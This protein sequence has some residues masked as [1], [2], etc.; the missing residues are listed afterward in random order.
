[1]TAVES[2]HNSK[3]VSLFSFTDSENCPVQ[4]FEF[5]LSKLNKKRDDLW[6]RPRKRLTGQEEEWFENAVIGRDPLE[7]TMKTLSI[8]AQLSK[9]YTNHSIRATVIGILD[10]HEFASRHIMAASGH[11]SESSIKSYAKKCPPKVHRDMSACLARELNQEA[12]PPK[13]SKPQASISK[14]TEDPS[15]LNVIQIPDNAQLI[16]A[17]QQEIS[18][19]QLVKVLEAIE[20]ENSSLALQQQP[21]EAE[22]QMQVVPTAQPEINAVNT[23]SNVQN[24]CNKNQVPMMYFHGSTVTINYNYNK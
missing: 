12:P 13:K 22:P 24:V 6:Q 15:V 16:E 10:E 20:K 11:K 21:Q 7:A 17:D 9:I 18:D 4:L 2:T 23:V 1:M 5:Y 3:Y 14:P 19:D 8:N